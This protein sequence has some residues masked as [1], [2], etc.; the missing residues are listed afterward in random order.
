MSQP[1]VHMNVNITGRVLPLFSYMVMWTGERCPLHPLTLWWVRAR[2]L[3]L[4]IATQQVR[5]S[6]LSKFKQH[7]NRKSGSLSCLVAHLVLRVLW[8][9]SVS[10]CSPQHNVKVAFQLSRLCILNCVFVMHFPF[11]HKSDCF[12]KF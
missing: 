1:L 5:G 11:L 9:M 12:P 8:T 7:G 6:L 2:K 10:P 4:P 3:F